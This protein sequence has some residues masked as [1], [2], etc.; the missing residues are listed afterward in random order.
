VEDFLKS[1]RFKILAAILVVL[2]SFMLH[3]A[4]AG[5]LIPLTSK[6]LGAVLT[7][8]MRLSATVS[9]TAGGF[10]ENI[11]NAGRIAEENETLQEQIRLLNEKLVDFARYKEENEQLRQYLELKESNPD[12]EFETASVIGRDPADR[13]Y[14]FTIDKGARHGVSLH[15]PVISSSGLVGMISEVGLTH[16]KVMTILDVNLNVGG[17]DIITR[18]TGVLAGTVEFSEQGLCKFGYLSREAGVTAGDIV[19]TTG[20]GGV[21]PGDLILGEITEVRPEDHGLSLYAV[22]SP[23]VDLRTIK[24]VLVIKSFEGKLAA[25][26]SA[27]QEAP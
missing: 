17:M 15:D 11:I 24:S 4:W 20:I 13:F 5:G 1:P 23:L 18:D 12:F 6:I 10:F 21:F 3:A 27:G 7:P 8:A 14:S 22:V 9:E 25:E 19:V 16:S 2:L 26:P